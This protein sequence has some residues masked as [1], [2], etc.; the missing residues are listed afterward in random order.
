MDPT[1]K[2]YTSNM[3]A[4]LI[5]E[6]KLDE[7]MFLIEN[8]I[9]VFESEHVD[10]KLRARILQ[11]K[12]TIHMKREEYKAAVKA[13]ESS[14]KE[15]KSDTVIEFLVEAKNKFDKCDIK[16]IGK[17]PKK[18]QKLELPVENPIIEKIDTFPD[19][20]TNSLKE[21]IVEAKLEKKS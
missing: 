14:L 3:I 9:E 17:L 12:G 1:D 20:S 7:A 6:K 16:E 13:F 19:N 2:V 8:L 10:F 15:S 5:E 11:R 21:Q 18:E 4:C